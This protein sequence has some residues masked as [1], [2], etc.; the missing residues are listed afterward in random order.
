MKYLI[1]ALAL[2]SSAAFA[3]TYVRGHTTKNGTY[4]EPHYRTSEDSSKFNN[5]STQGNVNPYNGKQGRIDPY[6][7]PAYQYEA[8][9]PYQYQNPYDNN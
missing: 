5:Y 6:T 7:P 2:V 8:P 1:L 9:K 3:D 4:V